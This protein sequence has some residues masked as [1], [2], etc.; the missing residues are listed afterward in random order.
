MEN[1]IP[2][3]LGLAF[4]GIKY[5]NKT[6]KDKAKHSFAQNKTQAP[7]ESHSPSLD[8]FIK[9][10]YTEEKTSFTE[11]AY[12]DASEEEDSLESWREQMHEQEPESI[13]YTDE[14]ALKK[15][16]DLQ[17]ETIQNKAN[18]KTER[19]DFDLRKAIVYDAIMNPPYL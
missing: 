3:L 4:L 14:H 12:A 6:Q 11:P 15:E 7:V 5:Y 8:D 19:L 1:L 16:P 18:L 13:E 10:F 2:I 17:F 9:Q